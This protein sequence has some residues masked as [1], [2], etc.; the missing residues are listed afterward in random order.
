MKNRIPKAAE[1]YKKKYYGRHDNAGAFYYSDYDEVLEAA[2]N[3]GGAADTLYNAVRIAL[4]AG[5]MI[6]YR[7]AQRDSR[8]NK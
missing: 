5:F 6:G 4:E 2:E 8:K 7:T 3:V 1:D